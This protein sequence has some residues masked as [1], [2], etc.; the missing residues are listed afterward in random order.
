MSCCGGTR[1]W[2]GGCNNGWCGSGCG[3]Y[4]YGWGCGPV[5]SPCAYQI[6]RPGCCGYAC[7]NVWF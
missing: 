3:G 4:G 5:C 7:Q 1:M 6:W 2:Y